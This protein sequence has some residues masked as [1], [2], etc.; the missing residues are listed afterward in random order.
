MFLDRT[1]YR[2]FCIQEQHHASGEEKV[3]GSQGETW[4][5][6]LRCS[7]LVC[8]LYE[9]DDRG[10][11][12]EPPRCRKEAS[13]CRNSE[14]LSCGCS[15]LCIHPQPSTSPTF[16]Q[17]IRVFG[18]SPD[19]RSSPAQAP[20]ALRSYVLSVE[21]SKTSCRGKHDDSKLLCR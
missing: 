15:L 12:H 9:L 14:T 11:Q 16:G 8:H 20:S 18:A 5:P 10:S 17:S 4:D 6:A 7:R 1:G 19:Q 3:G 21:L 13:S 2:V